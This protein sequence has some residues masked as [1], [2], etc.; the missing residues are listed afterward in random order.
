[1]NRSD[2]Q[3]DFDFYALQPNGTIRHTLETVNA[4]G[5]TR[6]RG[7]EADVTLRATERLTLGAS[8]AYTHWR[9]PPTPNP[10]V[11]GNPLQPLYIVYTPRHAASG[12]IDYSI[13]IGGGDGGPAVRLH[14][15]GNYSG[16]AHTFDNEN[17]QAEPSFILN[18]R[19]SLA[20]ISMGP[21]GQLLTISAWSRNLLDEQHIYRRSNANRFPIDGNFG[22]VIGDYANFNAPRTFGL[23]AAIRF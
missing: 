19:L 20:D 17:V 15:D 8:Y 7:I 3:F 23:E 10:L 5:T 22:T 1:M 11:P 21:G 4:P 14:L 6:I 16:R 2:S 12:S 13:P 18:A 9:V